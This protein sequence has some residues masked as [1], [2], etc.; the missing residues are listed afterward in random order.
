MDQPFERPKKNETTAT[1]ITAPIIDGT[2]AI[3]ASDGPQ[4][5]KIACPIAEPTK[6][7]TMLAIQHIDPPLFVIAPAIKPI[8]APTINT[9]NQCIFFSF[10]LL[11][12][13]Y[14]YYVT[15]N[16]RFRQKIC[17]QFAKKIFKP[18]YINVY[19]HFL[20]IVVR[21][22]IRFFQYWCIF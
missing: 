14:T 11:S 20:I 21:A 19:Q 7:A 2:I 13:Y 8:I 18:C 5:P 12:S 10:F 15:L 16:P 1:T 17:T 4:E 3:P 9:H 6:P 22:L